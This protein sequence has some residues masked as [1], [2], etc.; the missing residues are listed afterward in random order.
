MLPSPARSARLIGAIRLTAALLLIGLSARAGELVADRDTYIFGGDKPGHERSEI[1]GAESN[2]GKRPLLELKTT[3][4]M[5]D[6]FTRKIY[7]GF[8]IGALPRS[9]GSLSL[10]LN[11]REM[12]PGP[13]G[14]KVLTPQPI[15]V[16]LLKPG[17]GGADWTEGFGASVEKPEDGAATGG[18][19]WLN[20]PANTRRSGHRFVAAEVIEAGELLLPI[21]LEKNQEVLIPL[22]SAAIASLASG[23]HGARVTLMLSIPEGTDDLLR[24]HSREATKPSYRPALVW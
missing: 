8:D 11:L 1:A 4:G 9:L 7:L 18:L 23:R 19:H 3:A 12:N 5:G 16:Y 20:A 14:D 6:G 22:S 10:R 15:K 17:A 21:V 13:G 24:F 2:F